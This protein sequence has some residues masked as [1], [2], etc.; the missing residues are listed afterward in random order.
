MKK[1]SVKILQPGLTFSEPVYIE[2]NN[3]LVPAGV[4][5]RKKDLERL[6]TWGIETVETDGEALSVVPNPKGQT[7]ADPAASSG[8]DGS[9]SGTI[10]AQAARNQDSQGPVKKKAHM[11]SLTEVQENAGAYR[12]YIDL[13]ERLD[14][15]FN[16]IASG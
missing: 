11:L 3:L 4:A 14:G 9:S 10:P 16:N 12:S 13:I 15:V 6:D 1:I 8:R 7:A 5:I 2:G